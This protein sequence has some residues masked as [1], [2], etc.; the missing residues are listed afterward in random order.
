MD[1]K[2]FAVLEKDQAYN[3]SDLK[4]VAA[5]LGLEILPSFRSIR[6]RGTKGFVYKTKPVNA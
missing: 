6:Q 5:D 2:L 3:K 1:T 4:K